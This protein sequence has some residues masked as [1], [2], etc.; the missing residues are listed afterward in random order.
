MKKLFSLLLC[1]V[2]VLSLVA[3]G[4]KTDDAQTPDEPQDTASRA[5][6]HDEGRR[7]R[8]RLRS[9]FDAFTADTGVKV[10]CLSMSSGEVLSKLRA[11]GGTPSADLWFG[12]GIDAFMSAKDDGLLEPVTFDAAASSATSTRIPRVTGIPRASPL[13]ASCSTTLSWRAGSDRS[14]ELG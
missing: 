5:L 12:G 4:S 6:R 1:V 11:E 10:E 8:R 3:C 9:L 2:M 7:H 14:R 13:S